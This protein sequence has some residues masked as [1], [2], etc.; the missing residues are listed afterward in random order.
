LRFMS[1]Q[2][3]VWGAVLAAPIVL[4]LFRRKPLKVRVSTLLFFKSLAR[5]HQESAW[6]RRLK[7]LLSFLMSAAVVI[8]S[9]LAL[10]RLVV[11][12]PTGSL[13]SVV[14]L[15]DRSASMAA[16]DAGGTSRLDAAKAAVRE[17]LSG[18]PGGVSVSV[19]AYDRRPE[20]LLPRSLD[21]REVERALTSVGL[22]PIEGDAAGAVELARQLAA[23]DTPAAIWHATDSPG[24]AGGGPSAEAEA[25]S[26]SKEGIPAQ[27]AV[28][29][30]ALDV[31][32]E[33]ATNAGITA[34]QLRRLPLVRGRFEA[35][36]QVS[37]VAA[38][39]FDAK[40]EMRLDG[41]LVNVR[42]LT[43][44]PGAAE[45]LLVPV[46]AESGRTLSLEVKTRDDCLACDDKVHARVPEVRPLTVFWISPEPDPFTQLALTSLGDGGQIEV[47]AG[48]PS[49]WPPEEPPDV[50]IFDGWLPEDWPR[51]VATVVIDPPGPADRPD[52]AATGSATGA[53]TRGGPVRSVRLERGVPLASVRPT[54]ERHPVLY[55][56]ATARV[57]LTQTAV[58]ESNGPLEPL[59]VGASGPVLAAGDVRGQRIVAMAF[60]PAGSTRLPLMASFPLLLGNSIYWCASAGDD[61]AQL[62]PGRVHRT[63]D[64]VECPGRAITWSVPVPRQ[65]GRGGSGRPSPRE[66]TL[67][68]GGALVELDRIGLWRPGL[69]SAPDAAPEEGA[70]AALLSTAET[71]LGRRGGRM[72]P[73][74]RG[75]AAKS[76]PGDAESSGSS[77]D[78][79]RGDLSPLLVWIVL[80][81][82]LLESYLFHRRAVY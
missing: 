32:L 60:A 29:L 6:L 66:V 24:G 46:E 48:K 15:I 23:L 40:L 20:I 68:T 67:E 58:L 11:S 50:A 76:S 57:E 4:Y 27:G 82:L 9:T 34:F 26:P 42:E 21:R 74:G 18:L 17:R 79:L 75:R 43:I 73:G 8:L 38:G 13:R 16:T 2:L 44:E 36:V 3:L 12:P 64:L 78:F 33:S 69:A 51:D 45:R 1:P 49:A 71:L 5:E 56:V 61:G 54:D 35:F 72:A 53:A 47:L 65:A 81:V 55:G 39:P 10:A 25:P 80:G 70:A 14:I 31:S 41:A 62:G 7:R 30:Q 59:W 77:I 63:G 52:G 37:G 22:R 19:M 28:A